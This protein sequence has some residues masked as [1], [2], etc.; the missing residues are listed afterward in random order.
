MKKKFV[1]VLAL[2]LL[3]ASTAFAGDVKFSGR[4]RQG[5]VLTFTNGSDATITSQRAKEG[6]LAL[7]VAD[8]DGL[9]ALSFG[10]DLKETALDSNDKFGATATI[11]FSTALT[12]A[13]VDMKDWTVSM[14]IGNTGADT[15]LRAYNDVN[16]N[17]Y[18]KIKNNGKYSADVTVGYGKIAS[19]KISADPTT[20]GQKSVAITALVTPVDG[21]KVAAGYAHGFVGGKA[22][23]AKDGIGGAVTVDVAKLA[24]MKDFNLK[25]SAWD[26]YTFKQTNPD[27]DA[28]N[29]MQANVALGVAKVD[30]WVEYSIFDKTQNLN[31]QANFNL[32]KGMGLDAYFNLTTLNDA[33]KTKWN[34]GADVSYTFGGV[35]YS[36]NAEYNHMEKNNDKH[37]FALTPAVAISF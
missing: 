10:G 27:K 9:W 19:V 20:T 6:K 33:D 34:V 36:L 30:G 37:T 13:G 18:D 15:G 1:L 28:A 25:V 4:V 16:G 35:A 23:A 7:K 17:G 26:Q 22:T 2:V 8:A 14:G 5:Y 24:S 31:V 29:Y 32:V 12:K 11:N 3:V 21:V